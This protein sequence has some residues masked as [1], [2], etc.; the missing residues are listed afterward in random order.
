MKRISA[1]RR[2]REYLYVGAF[3]LLFV[4]TLAVLFAMPQTDVIKLQDSPGS[5]IL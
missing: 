2:V 5:Y 4:V 1:H 3:L